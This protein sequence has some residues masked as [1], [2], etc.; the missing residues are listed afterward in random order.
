M[1]A[2][3][4]ARNVGALARIVAS[5]AAT[6]AAAMFVAP[7]A[8]AQA[9]APVTSSVFVHR[10][11]DTGNSAIDANFQYI[12]HPPVR[13]VA[14]SEPAVVRGSRRGRRGQAGAASTTGSGT[15]SAP[16]PPMPSDVPSGATASP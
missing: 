1:T 13:P 7:M 16:L 11:Y 12:A 9:S 6:L 2:R 15:A 3:P 10:P 5:S 8:F 14:A 4:T